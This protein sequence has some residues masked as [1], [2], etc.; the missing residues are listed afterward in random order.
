MFN[1]LYLNPSSSEA[2]S[3]FHSVLGVAGFAV[4]GTGGGCSAAIRRYYRENGDLWF[5]AYLTDGDLSAPIFGACEL[6]VF[7][8]TADGEEGNI[9]ECLHDGP[10]VESIL[11]QLRAAGVPVIGSCRKVWVVHTYDGREALCLGFPDRALAVAWAS[12]WAAVAPAD[13]YAVVE[14]DYHTECC[15]GN[16]YIA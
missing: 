2:V 16:P 11:A 9:D 4:E 3:A 12:A 10:I 14:Y 5:S 1:A 6:S 13:R 15:F 7:A 8:A